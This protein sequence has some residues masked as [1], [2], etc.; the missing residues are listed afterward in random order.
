MLLICINSEAILLKAHLIILSFIKK[1]I[2]YDKNIYIQ[3]ETKT[4]L[5]WIL[6]LCLKIS[7]QYEHLNAYLK[8]IKFMLSN[9]PCIIEEI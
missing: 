3:Y 9:K 6:H 5:F 1:L 7:F 8:L 4:I 2:S